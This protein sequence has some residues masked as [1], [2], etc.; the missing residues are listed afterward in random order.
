MGETV[1]QFS[2]ISIS[3]PSEASSSQA[4]SPE[5]LDLFRR[6]LNILKSDG[7]DSFEISQLISQIN[8]SIP[9]DQQFSQIEI[10]SA[11]QI[12]SDNNQI[13]FSENVVYIV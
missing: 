2:E 11:L 8:G 13:F 1:S 9:V 4:I 7:T 5:R 6:Q 10:Q 3:N 12:M